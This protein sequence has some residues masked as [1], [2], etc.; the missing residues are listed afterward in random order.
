[1]KGEDNQKYGGMKFLSTVRDEDYN[2][3][4]SMYTTAGYSQFDSFLTVLF[5]SHD[6]DHALAYSSRLIGLKQGELVLKESSRYLT[7]KELRTIYG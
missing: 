4:R 7:K 2:Y 5:I 3:V 1:M 6:L